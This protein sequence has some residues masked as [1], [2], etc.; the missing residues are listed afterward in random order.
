MS[1][2]ASSCFILKLTLF[3]RTFANDLVLCITKSKRV[4][5]SVAVD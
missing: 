3:L 2:L 4:H 1:S 5:H